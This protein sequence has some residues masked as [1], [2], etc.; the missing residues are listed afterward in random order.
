MTAGQVFART[1]EGY[2]VTH[3]FMVPAM[4]R[5][6]MV[7]LEQTKIKRI[8]V[9]HESSGAYMA[10]GYARASRRPG[11]VMGQAVGNANIAAGLR[12]AF[13][14]GSPIIAISGGSPLGAKYRYVYQVVEDLCMFD[15]VTKFNARIEMPDRLP[16]L[17]RQAF[18]EATT[19]NPGPVHLEIPGRTGEG[20]DGQGQFDVVIEENYAQYPAFRPEADVASIRKAARALAQAERP[21]IVAGGGVIASGGNRELVKFAEL[22]SIPVA[23]SP[24]GKETIPGNHPLSIGVVGSYGRWS[25]NRTVEEADLVFFVGSRAGDLVTN[26]WKVPRPGT[27]VIQ[28]DIEPAEIGRHYPTMVT[29]LGDAKLTLSQLIEAVQAPQSRDAW[30]G[31]AQ[32]LLRQWR[33]EI[34]PLANS[35]AVPMRPERLCRE[36]SECLPPDAVIVSDTGHA[37]IWSGTMLELRH[38]SQRYIRCAGTLGWAFPGSLGVK[39]ALPNRPVLCF[40]GDGGI[41]YHIAELETAA[42]EAI[43]VVVVVNNN[44]SLQQVIKG[45][46]AAYGGVHPPKASEMWTFRETNFARIAEELGCVGIRVE[47][48]EDLKS[49]IEAAFAANR[50]VVIDAVSDIRAA[51]AWG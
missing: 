39:C 35:N 5:S 21:V 19:G 37:A 28:L 3:L 42:R 12:D 47:R 48:P 30:V 2:G 20:I 43:N 22:L 23:T 32:A 50:P 7:A 26:T 49:A 36:I 44:S 10:D 8:T 13:L 15:P 34:E 29:L 17:L 46:D 33:A 31:Q 41:W 27:N 24:S 6:G 1:L 51:P 38:A 14:A 9:H 4:F 18:R 16:D 25:A 11:I 45:F 40:T